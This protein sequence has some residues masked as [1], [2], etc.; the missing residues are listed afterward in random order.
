M[1]LIHYPQPKDLQVLIAVVNTGSFS[2]AAEVLGQ[3]PAF[4]TKRIQQM[5]SLLGVKLLNRSSR[6]MALTESGQTAYEHALEIMD[7]LQKL[8]D[9]VTHIKEQPVGMIRIGSS[10]G[11]GRAYIAPAIMQIMELYPELQI[12]FELFDRQIDLN[13]DNVDLDI[14]INDDIPENYIAKLLA[15]NRRILC[16]SPGYIQQRG[17]PETL[18]EL[19]RHDCLVTKERDQTIGVWEL[20]SSLGKKSVKISGHLSSNSGEIVLNWA[21][22][23]KGIMLR[24]EWDV[25]PFLRDGAL[26]QV[27]PEY[28][29]SANIWAVYQMPLYSSTKLKVCVEFFSQYCRDMGALTALQTVKKGN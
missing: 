23:G 19:Q 22:N 18:A 25:L 6:G 1:S 16:A 5:E 3:T 2:A 24:S 15:K 10:F 12:N 20:E 17:V 26:V 7:R 11:F 27:L 21:L 8:M 14:R 29:Q 28:A 4:V 13:R 9:E